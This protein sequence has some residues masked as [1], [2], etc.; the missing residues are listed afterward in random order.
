MI[1][2]MTEVYSLCFNH[3]VVKVQPLNSY[4]SHLN[5]PLADNDVIVGR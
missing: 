3:P 5:R 4:Y 2:Q 1:G